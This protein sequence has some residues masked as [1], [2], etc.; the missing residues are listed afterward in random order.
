MFG[1]PFGI[2]PTVTTYNRGAEL[3]THLTRVLFGVLC[4]HF[5]DDALILGFNF[6]KGWGQYCYRCMQEMLGTKLDPG[7]SQPMSTT[8]AYIGVVF[9]MKLVLPDGIVGVE[10]KPGRIQGILDDTGSATSDNRLC[11]GRASE[12]MGKLGFLG[13]HCMGNLLRG[14]VGP[15]ALRAHDKHATALNNDL[16]HALKFAVYLLE[17]FPEKKMNFG[18]KKKDILHYWS[19]AM[20]EPPLPA[21]MGIFLYKRGMR[22]SCARAVVPKYILTQLKQRQQMIGQTEALACL[23]GPNSFPD[24][25][26]D[27]DVMHYIDSTSALAG[28]IK[29]GSG[30]GDSNAIFQMHAIMIAKLRCKYWS[31]FVESNANLGDEPSRDQEQSCPIAE[32]LGALIT[33]CELPQMTNIFEAWFTDAQDLF[34]EH[35]R[36]IAHTHH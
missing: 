1:H 33:T 30:V 22:P 23:L 26:R 4:I 12:L 21:G 20:W 15:L 35:T 2:G 8:T 36:R 9:N 3:A 34:A 11:R 18:Q 25:F 7:K 24:L 10:P 5:Y 27:A 16:Q 28:I 29:G 32:S 31:E 13:T 19:D 17:N 14:I 6:E